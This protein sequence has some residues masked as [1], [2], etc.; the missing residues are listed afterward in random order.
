MP[1]AISVASV[2]RNVLNVIKWT[3]ESVRSLDTI[4]VNDEYCAVMV[5]DDYCAVK[6]L[7]LLA[8]TDR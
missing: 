4:M 2:L 8:W 3:R 6:S 5:N 7:A 1:S